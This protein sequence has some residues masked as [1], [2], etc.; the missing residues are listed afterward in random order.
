MYHYNINENLVAEQIRNFSTGLDWSKSYN[1]WDLTYLHDALLDDLFLGFSSLQKFY[2]FFFCS[3][4]IVARTRRDTFS[5]GPV[6][7]IIIRSLKWAMILNGLLT[8]VTR[9][10]IWQICIWSD[11]FYLIKLLYRKAK[12]APKLTSRYFFLSSV[13]VIQVWVSWLVISLFFW[14]SK[15]SNY[16][17]F[18]CVVDRRGILFT[19]SCQNMRVIW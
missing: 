14:T 18:H 17:I 4:E 13:Q 5:E 19:L 6:S 16:N 3:A 8:A 12:L 1:K 9:W 2:Q 7:L 10:Q 11:E 15:N